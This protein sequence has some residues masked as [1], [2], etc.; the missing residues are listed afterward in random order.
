M[1]NQAVPLYEVSFVNALDALVQSF[2]SYYLDCQVLATNSQAQKASQLLA[3]QNY[4]TL[5]QHISHRLPLSPLALH[6]LGAIHDNPII[7]DGP[8]MSWIYNHTVELLHEARELFQSLARRSR[9]W[10]A[11]KIGDG[12]KEVERAVF[13]E[14][15]AML[16]GVW[17]EE[18]A[19]IKAIQETPLTLRGERVR[20]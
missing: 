12:E 20:E 13:Y 8:S 14:G 4:N 16:I 17:K 7:F 9:E 18:L 6:F 19:G 3:A 2:K 5:L 10:V 11:T 1:S 15:W